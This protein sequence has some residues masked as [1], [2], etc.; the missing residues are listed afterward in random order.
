MGISTIGHLTTLSHISLIHISTG[1][2][3][4]ELVMCQKIKIPL[5]VTHQIKLPINNYKTEH[6]NLSIIKSKPA[7]WIFSMI[8][9]SQTGP[10]E[11]SNRREDLH[12]SF[13]KHLPP[14]DDIWCT[15]AAFIFSEHLRN[16]CITLFHCSRLYLFG[17]KN[18]LI[19]R[20]LQQ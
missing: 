12:L 3:H 20:F 5:N 17:W 13:G 10:W 2:N 16:G 19:I 4:N 18:V 11:S 15:T 6:K 7:V 8:L 14:F 1:W 9:L